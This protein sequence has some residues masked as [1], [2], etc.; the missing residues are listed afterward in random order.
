MDESEAKQFN[1]P[2]SF[3]LTLLQSTHLINRGVN[4]H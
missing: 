1:Y 4:K 3:C 2:P